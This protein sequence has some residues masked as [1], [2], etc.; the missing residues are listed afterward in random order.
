MTVCILNFLCNHET[1]YK[2]GVCVVAV[3]CKEKETDGNSAETMSFDTSLTSSRQIFLVV[4]NFCFL[5][6]ESENHFD[7]I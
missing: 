4:V 1:S 3:K 7:C 2:E 6:T 5:L